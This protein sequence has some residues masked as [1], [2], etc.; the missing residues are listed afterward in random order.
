MFGR[1]TVASR[2]MPWSVQ[3][4]RPCVMPAHGQPQRCGRA[5]NRPRFRGGQLLQDALQGGAHFVRRFLNFS[6]PP[7]PMSMRTTS[8]SIETFVCSCEKVSFN[9]VPGNSRPLVST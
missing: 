2:L 8:L 5:L 1:A 4:R 6:A 3:V 9:C 7:I